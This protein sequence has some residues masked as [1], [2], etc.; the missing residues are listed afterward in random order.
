MTIVFAAAVELVV[1][2]CGRSDVCS[3]S[4]CLSGCRLEQKSNEMITA[5]INSSE[6]SDESNTMTTSVDH[7]GQGGTELWGFGCATAVKKRRKER[8]GNAENG[9]P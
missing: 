2:P 1:I 3:T 9:K 4:T 6:P 5:A 8:C 7:C